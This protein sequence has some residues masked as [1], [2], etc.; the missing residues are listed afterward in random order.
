MKL[1]V[2]VSLFRSVPCIE[3]FIFYELSMVVKWCMF[4]VANPPPPSR[5]VFRR[6]FSFV[7]GGVRYGYRLPVNYFLC[8]V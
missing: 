1:Q 7:S 3:L 5:F 4:L 6:Q 2:L 8:Q